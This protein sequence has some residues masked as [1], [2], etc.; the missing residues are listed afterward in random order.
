M[1]R[2]CAKY[3]LAQITGWIV[4]RVFPDTL[5]TV[6]TVDLVAQAFAFRAAQ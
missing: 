3:N 6:Q 2:D 5:R 4:L 1:E